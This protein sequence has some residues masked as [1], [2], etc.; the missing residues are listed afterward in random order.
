[1]KIAKRTRSRR[2]RQRGMALLTIFGI[3]TVVA[4]V[5]TSFVNS[6][7]QTIRLARSNELEAR[8]TN[9]CEAG[10]Q[11]LLLTLWLP[12][13]NQQLF[14]NLDDAL[15]GAALTNPRGTVFGTLSGNHAYSA[16]VIGYE[17]T[18]SYNRVVLIRVV[19]W[20]DRNSNGAIDTGEPRKTVDVSTVFSLKRSPVFDY[21]YFVNNYGW[22][23]NFS[24]TSL[25]VSGDMRANGDFEFLG[26]IPTVNGSVYASPNPRLVPP[27]EG[28]VNLAPNQHTNAAYTAANDPRR[29]QAWDPAKHGAK[30]SDQYELWRDFLY[31]QTGQIVRNRISGSVIGDVGGHRTFGGTMLDSSPTSIIT[32]PDLNDINRYIELSQNYVDTRATFDDGTT[33]PD[34]GQGAYVKVWVAGH[35]GAHYQRVDTNG[36]VTGSA[37]L[38]GTNGHPIL[39][40]GP[41]TFTEDCVISGHVKGQGTIYTGRNVHIVGSIQYKNPPDFR[42]SNPQAIDN[43]NSAKD[44]LALAAR[45]S[46]I[47]GNVSQ[48]GFPHPLQ[49]M[50][51]PFTRGRWDDFGNWIPPFNAL[52]VDYT[53]RMRYQST[54]SDAQINDWASNVTQ[55][56]A[57]LYTNYLGGGQLG[58]GGGGVTMNGAIISKDEAMVIY[59]APL[60][61]NYDHRIRERVISRRPLIDIMLPRTPALLRSTWQDRG[62]NHG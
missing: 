26:G 21:V 23:Y 18:D 44:M 33:N 4:I 51:P 54:F 20:E 16:G 60:R 13:K 55:I 37:R 39:I 24:P 6:A 59:S 32:M 38:F 62:L 49:F 27:A 58:V 53:G 34:Y 48:F 52:E 2:Q 9:V 19:G 25:I 3:L 41:V 57:I 10:I 28:R 7:T 43:S 17:E 36:V 14:N 45:G 29:R 8:L 42:G 30:G 50:T 46:I 47:I 22:M 35:G 1:M 31:D 40:H 56:D 61:M 12:F 11:D 15:T 5:T